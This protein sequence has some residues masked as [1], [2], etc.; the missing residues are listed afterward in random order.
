MNFLQLVQRLQ[1]E[2]GV[3][4]SPIAT[5]VAQTGENSLLVN[6]INAAWQDLQSAHQDWGWLRTSTS[7][8]TVDGKS[9]YTP[10]EAGTTN[11]GMWDRYTFRCYNTSAGIKSEI[12]MEYVEYDFWRDG[13]L[14]GALRDTRSQGFVVAVAPAD[15]SVCIGPVP[16]SGYTIEADY[17]TQA[18]EMAADADTPAMPSKFHMAIVYRAMIHYGM[19]N[20]ASEVV[21][22]G[23][24]EYK[25][26]L[27]RIIIDRLPEITVGPALA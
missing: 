9:T 14:F 10:T 13:Y 23:D 5:T 16:A 15:K 7:F 6:W 2:C 22:R 27:R 17:Y 12:F 11:F 18:T 1:A 24:M 19:Y 3:S 4:G 25:K 20:A 8:V 21:Q 26:I